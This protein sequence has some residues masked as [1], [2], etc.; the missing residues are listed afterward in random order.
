[1]IP[2]AS[3]LPILK[4]PRKLLHLP[5]DEW[6]E[7]D[8][9]LFQTAFETPGDVF[10]EA[11]SGSRLKPRTKGAIRY[12]YRRWLG[13]VSSCHPELMARPPKNRATTESVRAYIVHLRTTCSPRTVATQVGRLY[14]ALR[15]MDPAGDR[16]WLKCIKTRLE[17]ATPKMGRKPIETSSQRVFDAS[18]D[19]LDQ[20]DLAFEA[21]PSGATAKDLQVLALRYRDALLVAVVTLLPLRR[22]NLAQLRLG[23]TIKRKGTVWSIAIPGDLVKNG[24]PIVADLKAELSQRVERYV[25]I[26]R[27]LI[28]RSSHHDGFW[29]SAK[30]RPAIGQALYEAFQ[31]ETRASL[32]LHMTLHDARRVGATTWAMHDPVNARGAKD[33]LGDRS[34]RVFAQHYNLANGIEASRRMAK[35]L[36]GLK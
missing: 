23:S 30:G 19:R 20:V 36:S 34:D 7:V 28:Y 8:R 27:P 25:V 35:L 10:D 13:W 15:F 32:G 14:D 5:E 18:L 1:M 24:E 12:G 11:E 16:S 9:R 17:N 29:A 6:P 4:S 3:A 31:K 26:Y 2:R 33:L 21:M 22:T